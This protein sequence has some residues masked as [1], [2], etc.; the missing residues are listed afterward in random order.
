MKQKLRYLLFGT[1][2][3]ALACAEPGAPVPKPFTLAKI[4]AEAIDTQGLDAAKKAY[5]EG[6]ES[7]FANL[8]PN[9]GALNQLGYRYLSQ[10]NIPAAIFV[11]RTNA[12]LHLESW[13]VYDSLGEVYVIAGDQAQATA[14]FEKSLSLNPKNANASEFLAEFKSSPDALK[15]MQ[16]R[17]RFGDALNAAFAAQQKDEPVDLPALRAQL[18][19]VV[20]A[21]PASSANAAFV[22]NFLYLSE[23]ADLKGAVEDWRAFAASPNEQ[24]KSL[25]E[26]KLKLAELLPR[27]VE[28][29]F[30]SID[31]RD[32]DVSALRGK[33]VLID[34][35]ATWC[36]PCVHEI[37]NLVAV[38]EKFHAQGFE[39]VGISFDQAP[40]AAKPSKRQKT[41]ADVLSFTQEKHMPW[42]QYYDG[43]YWNNVFGKQY[44]IRGIPAMFL[45]DQQGMIISTNARGPKLE[46]EVKRLLGL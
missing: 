15:T 22:S 39:V 6:K 12:Q 40:D 10:Q 35:W 4:L 29:K 2:A 20:D 41:A 5:A 13:N 7:D 38:Y 27:P 33:V 36:G 21:N 43:L 37:P 46:R 24:V 11:L 14:N 32:V 3:A 18:H 31:G 8:D 16:A 42:S 26:S 1:L 30:K 23:S 28:M 25:A 9:E 45:L 44:G 19:A 17:F 34:F